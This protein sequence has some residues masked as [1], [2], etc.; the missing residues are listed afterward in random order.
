MR[1]A[2]VLGPPGEGE[3]EGEGEA[4]A[5]AEG[6]GEGEG[7]GGGARPAQQ[8]RPALG[9][10]LLEAELL[11]PLEPLGAQHAVVERVPV[12]LLDRATAR[13]R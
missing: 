4:E 10:A 9:V 6:E 12:H 5:E 2:D 8:A 3:G 7:E 1:S 11:E 13:V